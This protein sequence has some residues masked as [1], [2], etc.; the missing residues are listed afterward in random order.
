MIEEFKENYSKSTS[1]WWYTQECFAYSMLNR[2]LGTQEVEILIKMDFFICDQ[3]R[4]QLEELHKTIPLD[5]VFT[6]Y[7]GQR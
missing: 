6:V 7:R 2:A 4:R 5:D 3:L 1:I